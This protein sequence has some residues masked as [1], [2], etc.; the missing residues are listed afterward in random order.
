MAPSQPLP[1][2]SLPAGVTPGRTRPLSVSATLPP[3]FTQAHNDLPTYLPPRLSPS[4]LA[5]GHCS[6][7]GTARRIP[8]RPPYLDCNGFGRLPLSAPPSLASVWLEVLQPNIQTRSRRL[9]PASYRPVLWHSRRHPPAAPIAPCITVLP[10]GFART[11]TLPDGLHN[12]A[13]AG[14]WW[15]Y[16]DH[17]ALWS[18]SGCTATLQSGCG[19]RRALHWPY[20][21]DMGC[22]MT[23]A[24]MAPLIG[25][26]Q[27]C[28]VSLANESSTAIMG[29]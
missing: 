2:R 4:L 22:L 29:Q 16:C 13:S 20:L 12:N 28:K 19:D 9:P 27:A 18:A 26:R 14:V 1:R 5:R 7:G 3:P 23:E 15:D 25:A 24:Y 21:A 8:A 17:Y 11:R 6:D 10:S